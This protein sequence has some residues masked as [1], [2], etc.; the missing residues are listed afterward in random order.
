[1]DVKVIREAGFADSSI[2]QWRAVAEKALRGASFDETLVSH[3]DDAITYGPLYERREDARILSRCDSASP[4]RIV[5]RV[6]DPDTDRAAAQAA[7]A[8]AGARS[9]A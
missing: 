4:W 5:Q 8:R 2:E 1:M 9:G 6:D 7:F 3:T